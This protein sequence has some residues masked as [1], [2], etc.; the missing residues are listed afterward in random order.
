M[1]SFQ[2]PKQMLV[3]K[4]F[5]L[6]LRGS[7]KPVAMNGRFDQ[8]QTLRHTADFKTVYAHYKKN[9]K[10]Y[11]GF[12]FVVNPGDEHASDLV[13]CCVDLDKCFDEQGTLHAWARE[14]VNASDTFTEYSRSGRG[15]HLFF[16]VRST[17]LKGVGHKKVVVDGQEL[18]GID[19]I[20]NTQIAITGRVF[21]SFTDVAIVDPEWMSQV[22]PFFEQRLLAPGEADE[23]QTDEDAV[24]VSEAAIAQCLQAVLDGKD[25][26][27][28]D[29]GDDALYEAGCTIARHGISGEA[30][31]EI[32]QRF[33]DEKCSPPWDEERLTYKIEQGAE[34]VRNDGQWGSLSIDAFDALPTET[35]TTEPTEAAVNPFARA[36]VA[37]QLAFPIDVFPPQFTSFAIDNANA[38]GC[39]VSFLVPFYIGGAAGC[40]GA[41]RSMQVK[42]SWKEPL[43][44]WLAIIARSGG[45]KSPA[46][47]NGTIALRTIHDRACK[48]HSREWSEWHER[49]HRYNLW[50]KIRGNATEPDQPGDKP[51]PLE[52]IWISSATTEQRLRLHKQNPYGLALIQDELSGA[53]RGL[54]EYKG[55]Q[56]SDKEKLLSSWSGKAELIDRVSDGDGPP[57][58]ADYTG[59]Q[60]VGG[61]QPEVWRS[62]MAAEENSV[63]GMAARFLPCYPP[64]DLILWNDNDTAP[65]FIEQQIEYLERL[66]Q[67]PMGLD[68]NLQCVPVA[69]SWADDAARDLFADFYNRNANRKRT[70]EPKL[71]AEALSK[72]TAYCARF[73][74]LIELLWHVEGYG[75]DQ[76]V[77]LNSVQSAI[78]LVEWFAHEWTRV[79]EVLDESETD[80]ERRELVEFIASKGGAIT[81]T[82]LKESKRAYRGAGAAEQALVALAQCDFGTFGAPKTTV[83]GGRPVRKFVLSKEIYKAVA[84]QQEKKDQ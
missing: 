12:A 11:E 44:F 21:E 10:Q 52:R 36:E 80:K 47:E 53:I 16:L 33:N 32:M 38:I 26:V 8:W 78:K 25:S 3:E 77:S 58:Y 82:Q 63:N 19:T 74:A 50:K 42:R 49:E 45:G 35:R 68:E 29:G 57:Q 20:F 72:M 30:A 48:E 56:G 43:I 17:P 15:L 66:R 14:I 6:R 27:E 37:N 73:A 46:Y 59:L 5:N 40:V 7:K 22:I 41:R 4:R 84:K 54:N 67:L 69:M 79:L 18:G 60:V 71:F 75:S 81:P 28:G 76:T 70:A 65:E 23:T 39:D 24:E 2:L 64:D 31:L 51:K 62:L 1:A 55:G 34:T 83:A 13:W 9:P 61:S